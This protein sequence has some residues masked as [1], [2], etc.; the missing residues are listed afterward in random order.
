M[1]ARDFCFWLQGFLELQDAERD[2]PRPPHAPELSPVTLNGAQVA[3]LR[4]HLALVFLHEIDPSMGGPLQQQVLDKAHG[5]PG[6]SPG[7]PFLKVEQDGHGG[8]LMRC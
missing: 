7:N 8:P 3:C 1:Q 6:K 4:R 5:G 2:V